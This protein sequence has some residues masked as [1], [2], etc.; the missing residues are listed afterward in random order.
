MYH[1]G[2]YTVCSRTNWKF[3]FPHICRPPTATTVGVAAASSASYNLNPKEQTLLKTLQPSPLQT[4]F[5]ICKYTNMT[6]SAR[7]ATRCIIW[8]T[9]VYSG[10][11]TT[12]RM[13]SRLQN[14]TAGWKSTA[15]A[16]CYCCDV[17]YVS[18][19]SRTPLI[20]I[21]WDGEPSGYAENPD[22]SI[23]IWEQAVVLSSAATI[24]NIY[25]STTPDLKF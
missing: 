9:L 20:R 12:S 21:N 2:V 6:L 11:R 3:H 19:Y 10:V 24:Y 14:L 18:R 16:Y 5:E 25:P 17:T 1:N 13:K 8:I 15:H 23:L 4:L 22:N 7:S